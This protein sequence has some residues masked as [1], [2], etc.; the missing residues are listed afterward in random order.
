MGF[1]GSR[2]RTDVCLCG[3]RG[4]SVVISMSLGEFRGVQGGN[5]FLNRI[6][7][8][9]LVQ[10]LLTFYD[11]GSLEL[12]LRGQMVRGIWGHGDTKINM[13]GNCKWPL[14]W[15]QPCLSCLLQYWPN[16]IFGDSLMWQKHAPINQ[17]QW[18]I[19]VNDLSHRLANFVK[20]LW[21]HSPLLTVYNLLIANCS[22]SAIHTWFMYY[23]EKVLRVNSPIHRYV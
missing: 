9:W 6:E 20:V 1:F 11:S 17:Q 4:M 23:L 8:S 18:T 5:E 15:R 7:L 2:G 21:Q 3:G 13:L 16:C 19:S 10:D 14:P 12:W 22:G